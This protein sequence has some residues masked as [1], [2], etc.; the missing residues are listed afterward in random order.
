MI[1]C[2]RNLGRMDEGLELLELGLRLGGAPDAR[3]ELLAQGASLQI[4]RGDGH[5]A[6]ACIDSALG[7]LEQ[8]LAKPA[9]LHA[10]SRKRRRDLIRI[11][12][13]SLALRGD[14]TLHL[15]VGTLK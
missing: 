1:A 3:A 11:Q 6:R 15:E 14:I 5:A 13:G 9:G 7:L 10:R 8:E 12:A 4:Q 2:C